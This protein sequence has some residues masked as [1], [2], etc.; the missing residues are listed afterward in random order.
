MPRETFLLIYINV[1][2][3]PYLIGNVELADIIS[4][5]VYISNIYLKGNSEDIE[6]YNDFYQIEYDS[7]E[8]KELSIKINDVEMKESNLVFGKDKFLL[9]SFS[10]YAKPFFTITFGLHVRP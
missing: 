10:F 9:S 6:T 4:P 8:E 3:I 2:N 1:T 5:K 7:D